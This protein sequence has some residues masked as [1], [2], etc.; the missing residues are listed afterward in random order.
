MSRRVALVVNPTS[1]RGL[2]ARIA[3]LIRE[4]LAAAGLIV[5]VHSTTCAEAV[6]RI[7]FAGMQYRSD[8][9]LSAAEGHV[10]T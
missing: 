3:P 10:R 1:G 6:G 4:R 7:S 8:I 5:D 9:A 2:G